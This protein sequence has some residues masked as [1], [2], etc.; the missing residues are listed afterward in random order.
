MS[1]SKQYCGV[2]LI[3]PYVYG[4]LSSSHF[5]DEDESQQKLKVLVEIKVSLVFVGLFP[6]ISFIS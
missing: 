2:L 5:E 4:L 1:S 3:F 6:S